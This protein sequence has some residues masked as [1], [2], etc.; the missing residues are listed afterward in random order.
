MS[1]I[2]DVELAFAERIPKLNR[3]VSAAADNLP[4]VCAEAHTQNV[5]SVSDKSSSCEASVEVPETKSMVP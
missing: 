3:S 4:V 1:L 5:T 2:L